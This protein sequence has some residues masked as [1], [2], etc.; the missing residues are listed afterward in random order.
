MGPWVWPRAEPWQQVVILLWRDTAQHG[1]QLAPCHRRIS[2]ADLSCLTD[3]NLTTVHGAAVQNRAPQPSLP[4]DQTW[5]SRRAKF[6]HVMPREWPIF[7]QSLPPYPRGCARMNQEKV[8][9][10]Q[11]HTQKSSGKERKSFFSEC[12]QHGVALTRDW[13]WVGIAHKG[14]YRILKRFP[15]PPPPKHSFLLAVF[16]C[17]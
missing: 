12:L 14:C 4:L 6:L 15:S 3:T 2:R 8:K 13:L 9:E 16:H 10:R 11:I 5:A 17:H 7:L 1:E